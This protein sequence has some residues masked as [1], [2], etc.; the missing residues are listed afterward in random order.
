MA[1]EQA[2]GSGAGGRGVIVLTTLHIS[3]GGYLA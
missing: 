3:G 1:A 2:P